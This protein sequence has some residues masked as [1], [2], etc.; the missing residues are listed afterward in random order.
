MRPHWIVKSI[1]QLSR[2]FM[3]DIV[4]KGIFK[5]QIQLTMH[6]VNKSKNPGSAPKIKSYFFSND[7]VNH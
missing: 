7:V 1:T 5:V 2:I 3:I 6:F 4:S